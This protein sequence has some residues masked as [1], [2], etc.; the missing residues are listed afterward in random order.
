MGVPKQMAG[1]AA[2]LPA[3]V[4]TSVT[5]ASSGTQDVHDVPVRGA[6]RLEKRP[7]AETA[8]LETTGARLSS[9]VERAEQRDQ[10]S[11]T[12]VGTPL[13]EDVYPEHGALVGTTPL[14]AVQTMSLGGGTPAGFN[15]FFHVC[16]VPEEDDGFEFPDPTNPPPIP[17]CVESGRRAGQ[18]TWRVPAG[19][20]TWGKQYEWWVRV[21]D[22]AGGGSAQ[23]D[24][25]SFTTGARQP[26]TGAHLGE[27]GS[28]GQEFAPISGN[29]TTTVTDA[30]VAAVGPPLSVTRTYN[31]LESRTDGIFGAG[32]SS[33]WDMKIVAERSGAEVAGLLVFYPDGRRVRFASKGDGGYQPPP[34]M[35]AVLSD[36]DGGG[37]LL[38]DKSSTSFTFNA[39]GRL[40]QISDA[41][42]RAQTLTYGSDGKLSKAT[43]VGGR[44]LHF[45][46]SG[47]RVA[48][49]STD[50]VDGE[51]LTWTYGY[52]GD[53]LTQV[54]APV[55]APNC[56]S[57]TYADG[58]RY[59]SIVQD[60][61]PVGYWR[62]GEE[63]F[64]SAANEGSDGRAGSYTDVTVGQPGALEGSADT[65]AGFTKSTVELPM[66]LLA[67][68]RDRVAIEGWFKTTQSGMIFSAAPS[69]NAF[70]AA[71]P[72]LYVGTDGR[73]RG[74]LGDIRNSAG[75]WVY[76][77]ITTADPVND[78]QW[79]HVALNVEGTRQQLF[80][81]GQA[82]GEVNGDFYHE[83]RAR[84]FI[85][86][87]QRANSWST[88]PGGPNASGVFAFKGS[89][90]EFA[91][92]DKPLT[93]AEIQAHH[94][95]RAKVANKLTG[96][97]LP[98]ER[99]W[100]SNTYDPATDRL[101]T[102]TDQHGGTWQIGEPDT[103]WINKVTTVTVTDPRN[104]TVKS[105]YDG[106]RNYRVVY[107][108]DQH[109][110]KTEYA[111]D[112]GGF[113]AK[114]TD[115]NGNVWRRWN[116]KRGNAIRDKSCRTGS[117]CQTN[118]ASYYLNEDDEFDPRNDRQLTYR[119]AR[120]SSGTDNTYATTY[121]Y[122]A[123]GEPT[124]QTGPATLDFPT[125][126]FASVTYT[127]GS[128]PAVGGG[129]TPAGLPKTATD[130]RANSWRYRYNA[131]GDLA[132][133]SAPEGL[134]TEVE[135]DPLGRVTGMTEV[136]GAHPAG[137]KTI[138]TY[139]A[140]N[141][142]TTQTEPGVKNEV[143]GV[144]HTKRV[145][146]VYDPDGNRLS[147]TVADL[148]GGDAERATVYT[149][150]DHGRAETVTDPEGGVVRQSWNTRGQPASTTDARG[151]LIEHAY[152]KRGELI[153]R[154]LKGWTGS[155]VA[156]QPATDVV[157]EAFTYDSGGR[158]ATRTDAMGRKTSFTYYADD[159][160]AQKI[161][162]QVKLNGS[163][164]AKNVILEDHTFDAAGNRTKLITGGGTTTTEYVYD[165]AGLLSSQTLDPGV[166]RR[167]TAF[168][169]DANGNIVKTTRTG[170]GS[171][172]SEVTEFTYN[173]ENQAT[174]Q[175]V[176]NG[177]QDL[178]STTAYDERGLAIAVT[179]PRGNAEGATKADFTSTMRH[180][181]LG[182][183]VQVS[184]PQVQVDKAG[185]A[186]AAQPKAAFGYD[187][188]GVQTHESDA[189]G[190]TVTSVFDKAGRLTSQIAPSY[191]PPGGTA[192]TPTT[193]HAYDP[194][195]QLIST[196]D[197]RGFTTTFEYDKLGRQVRVTDPA[198]DG[199]T[200]GRWV[201]EYDLVGEK[202]AG[203]DPTGAR[204]EATYDDLGRQI[205]ATEIERKP[206]ATVATTTLTYNDAGHLLKAVAPGNK[207]TEHTV[208]A[209][210]EV[211]STTDPMINKST[212]TYDL[213][214][215]AVTATDPRNNATTLEYDLAGRQ[216]GAKDLDSAGT[217]LRTSTSTYDLA[218][219]QI[220]ATSPEGHL[221]RQTYDAL[222]RVTS[223]IEPVSS[224]ESITTGFGYDA[225]GARTRLTDGRGN[226]TWST[227]NSLG[228]I[229][230]LTEPATAAHPAAADRTWTS[231]YDAAGNS[232]ATLQPGGV[233]IDREFDHLGRLAEETGGGGGA[234]SA[235]RTFGYDPAGR[236]TAI[237]DLTVDYNDRGLP[238]SI[239]KGTT[240]QSAYAYDLLGNPTQRVDAAG[241]ATFTWDKASRLDTA[242]DPVTGRKLTYGYDKAS[243][244]ASLTA[245]QG[246]TTT[247]TQSFTYDDLDRP[248]THTL[249]KGAGTGTQLAKITYGWDKDD[250]LT[251]KTTAGTAGA[252]ANTYGYDH[253]GRLTSWTAPGGASTAYEWDAA[254]NRTKAG[255]KTY[256][257]DERNRMTS[258][259][260]STYTYTPRGTLATEAKNGTTTQLTFDAFDRLIADG[261]SV[262]SYDALDRLTSRIRGVNKQTFA[263]SGLSNN[264]AAIIDTLGGL[265]ARYGRDAFGALL[266]QQEGANPAHATLTDLHGDLVATYSTTALATTTAYDPFGAITDQT[267]VKTNLGYQGAYTD[268]DTGK[269]NMHARWYQPG[270]GTFTSRDTMTLSPNPSV[271]AN[272]YT[273]ANASPMTGTDP[274]GHA[275][276]TGTPGSGGHLDWNSGTD[277]SSYNGGGSCDWS[278][279]SDPVPYE[280][281]YS[282]GEQNRGDPG[283]IAEL[284]PQ[285]YFENFILDNYILGDHTAK[286]E[287]WDKAS[288]KKRA[289]YRAAFE[290]GLTGEELAAL[291][292]FLTSGGRSSAGASV[293]DAPGLLDKQACERARGKK[294][295]AAMQKAA[296]NLV[297]SRKFMQGCLVEPASV[298]L[299]GEWQ[300]KLGIS[301]EEKRLLV[302]MRAR[303]SGSDN[304]VST[305]LS[306]AVDFI[307]ADAM[308]CQQGDYS[309]CFMMLGSFVPGGGVASK[310]VSKALGQLG[311]ISP[312]VDDAA[313]LGKRLCNSFVAGTLVLMADGSHKSIEKIVV[314]D[315][316]SATDPLTDE[317]AAQEVAHLIVGT[318]TKDLVEITV[319]SDS[320][321]DEHGSSLIATAEHPFWVPALRKW[322]DAVDL[323]P[324]QWLQT[325]AGTWVRVDSVRRQTAA[326]RVHNLSVADVHT[327]YVSAGATDLLVHN[328]NINCISNKA[329]DDIARALGYTK[330]KGERSVTGA[331]IWEN[332]KAKAGQPRYITWDKTGHKGGIFK[333]ANF[334]KPFRTTTDAGRDGTYDL[335]ISDN[336]HLL[337]LKWIAK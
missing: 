184:G 78:D 108:E 148:T 45:T 286:P 135:R 27:R 282:W 177:E 38:M 109:S 189:E 98:S 197:P 56:T 174:K 329:A 43:A 50:P 266:G 155:P 126:R 85:G 121:E 99:V 321:R 213:A 34:G 326:Q 69:G 293:P 12:S 32:W 298:S 131:S 139:D 116:D 87:G 180:D 256:A 304:W 273:Y 259:D 225:T 136:L 296:D 317:T 218:G 236:T 323:Q 26:A 134:R 133:Q 297:M 93:S 337:G 198:P 91:I 123:H 191:T 125:G 103:D 49:V 24:K 335:L 202:L 289:A 83:Y 212:V 269:A 328:D 101:K 40:V 250:N 203:L 183:V 231:V 55:A 8:T 195:G 313:K 158:L 196:T 7:A 9:G 200:P 64:E 264:L 77:P 305:I 110:F 201:A 332:K 277:W 2:G 97:T 19:E 165:A 179:D 257:Y 307:F 219:N 247:D 186:G 1:T 254:G 66:Y 265:Q 10:Q 279:C 63:Q 175:S 167:K 284:D 54:C 129:T 294:E 17:E 229:E 274:T 22:Q 29:Y 84:A 258:G 114:T 193:S 322:V 52:E 159:L 267:G 163:T 235:E 278:A 242:T 310:G 57:Y 149:Y 320:A 41:R 16:E 80:L 230:T 262:Y 333:G 141:R 217:V 90:D 178:I 137:V 58:S 119:D 168:T 210:G 245:V 314:G 25:R 290:M 280:N 146:Y 300:A 223:L 227:Y 215:R 65:A 205:T 216:I 173:K 199:Q 287:D 122:N 14:L 315:K 106:W 181:L 239:L 194:A 33:L 130:A 150:D 31:S 283:R 145:T 156:P 35:H 153:T 295:C 100:A 204:V 11:T 112:T 36:V 13:I 275:T 241:T 246:T 336:G 234:A 308:A 325:S 47:P 76:A 252:G 260:G 4:G 211:T 115:R 263:Y 285:W 324:G 79:H 94:A 140:L 152:S 104:G 237:G 51:S 88:I 319:T 170:A 188:L 192:V 15:F 61:E 39:S 102:H 206:T 330:K 107:E 117:N 154:T 299:C 222:N 74:Q 243:N 118:Y 20:L 268:P 128:E 271:Q 157:L 75:S 144:T 187:T 42:G 334:E 169:Y 331:Y 164:T 255:D 151:A 182:R 46:W 127:D 70:G 30:Q 312:K 228:L 132:E 221:T 60:S 73:L 120:S 67:R 240:Q 301:D 95:A 113:P 248:H 172:R 276:V 82:V 96:T 226:A 253:A 176:E 3:L 72:V 270:T 59:R 309:S 303:K 318:G 138:F 238:L 37:W 147:E 44:S 232:V 185:T 105:G 220:T 23:T 251:T 161:A 6:L 281:L 306:G 209:A 162:D 81:D 327:Y 311:K 302:Q 21:V 316:V 261:D 142:L 166:L 233:R 208:N 111:Y 86:S 190:R 272:R 291:W 244:L 48:T 68:L 92:Y 160:P 214:G 143:S 224:S 71:Q 292:Q 5:Q 62:L 53:N 28:G 288:L 89:I 124:K 207:S 171:T 249:N 18:E